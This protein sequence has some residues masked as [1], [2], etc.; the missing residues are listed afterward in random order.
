MYAKENEVIQ[1]PSDFDPAN[2]STFIGKTFGSLE[3]LLIFIAFGFDQGCKPE[4]RARVVLL[5]LTR[6]RR[7]TIN[8]SIIPRDLQDIAKGRHHILP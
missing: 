2:N 4:E 5:T 6:R 7:N 3:Q 1:L 8:Q